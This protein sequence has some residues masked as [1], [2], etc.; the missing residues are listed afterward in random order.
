MNTK[1]TKKIKGFSL[2]LLLLLLFSTNPISANAAPDGKGNYIVR[3]N[4]VGLNMRS[5]PGTTNSIL[6]NI[7]DGKRVYITLVSNT[8]WGKTTYGGK[9]G[10]VHLDY[11]VKE[12]SGGTA[13][14]PTV[15]PTLTN[16]RDYYDGKKKDVWDNRQ[17]GQ[18]EAT[19]CQGFAVWAK[20]VTSGRD[21]STWKYVD[22]LNNLK[23]GDII[24]TNEGIIITKVNGSSVTYAEA[25][26]DWNN[27][28]C[29]SAT[30]TLSNLQKIKG[31]KLVYV[32]R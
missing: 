16:L 1:G 32:W 24:R 13:I 2:M 21:V 26:T 29:W 30:T 10:Y 3:A 27:A 19:E 20:Y 23:V 11:A 31:Y 4:G 25:N 22:N 28:I 8:Y 12:S 6:T 5:V 15:K 17:T 14:K 18:F 7:P 9:T